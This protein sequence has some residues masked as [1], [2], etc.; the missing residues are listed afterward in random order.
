[1]DIQSNTSLGEFAEDP[2]LEDGPEDGVTTETRCSSP[3]MNNRYELELFML[4]S[5]ICPSR[6]GE[7]VSKC[8]YCIKDRSA[9]EYR[10]N[11]EREISL[12]TVLA[13]SMLVGVIE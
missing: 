13:C 3:T 4:P 8:K 9:L 6:R 5:K 1:V 2:T 11:V 7:I 10:S 12:K